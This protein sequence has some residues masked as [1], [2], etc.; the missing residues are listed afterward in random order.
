M[1]QANAAEPSAELPTPVT[2][3]ERRAPF[4]LAT[5]SAGMI[6]ELTPP[7][8]TSDTWPET[9]LWDFSGTGTD[10]GLPVGTLSIDKSGAIYGTTEGGTGG[11]ANDG[12]VYKLV[13]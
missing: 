6:F 13:P 3:S 1:S 5:T 4:A 9:D 10:G 7:A 8:S 2:L 11:P 12:T